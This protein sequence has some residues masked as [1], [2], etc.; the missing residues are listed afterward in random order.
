MSVAIA[1]YLLQ[2]TLP[3]VPVKTVTYKT[4]LTTTTDETTT[5]W[6][7]VDI[8]TPHPK[9]VV[10]LAVIA[11][12]SGTPTSVTVNGI[13]QYHRTSQTNVILTCY[14]VPNGTTADIVVSLSG[15]LRKAVGVYVF[16]PE[17][18]LVMGFGGQTASAGS[19]ATVANIRCQA[20]GALFYAVQ[21]SATSGSFTT[22]WNGA[23][24]ETLVEDVDAVLESA[25]TYTWGHVDITRSDTQGDVSA[26]PGVNGSKSIV[27]I[28]LGPPHN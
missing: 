14:Q 21:Q 22:T 27:A 16:Y 12:T 11:G 19:A 10:I 28:T 26:S 9:R 2:A 8:G 25:D 24:G 7:S 4:T 6:T 18:N 15:S 23:G 13:T 3:P 5:T 1:K 17:Q 20:G